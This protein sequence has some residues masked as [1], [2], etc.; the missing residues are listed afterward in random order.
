MARFE[1]HITIDATIDH[2]WAMMTNPQTWESWFPDV[3]TISGLTAVQAGASFE[4]RHGADSGTGTITELDGERGLLGVAITKGADT[5]THVFDLDR[6]GGFFGIGANDTRLLY[7]RD[8]KAEGGLIGEFIAGGNIVDAL[9]VK[10]TLAKIKKL[11][12]A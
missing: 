8:Y 1:Q 11:A 2:V 9:E 6:A 12:Q 10:Q 4:W 7:R 5:T 3:D